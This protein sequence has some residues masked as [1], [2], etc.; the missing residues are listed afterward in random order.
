MAAYDTVI[1]GYPVWWGVAP[2]IVETFLESYDFEGK[3]L[4]AF[5]TSGG[6][7][8]GRSDLEL[9]KNVKGNVVWKKGT[10]INRADAKAIRNWLEQVL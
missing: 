5:C 2:R 9:H 3:T 8:L 10:Q 6:S 7:G 4:A 1:V